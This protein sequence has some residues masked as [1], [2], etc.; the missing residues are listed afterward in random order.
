[1][2][3][4]RYPTRMHEILTKPGEPPLKSGEMFALNTDPD[5][6]D[7]YLT[8]GGDMFLR[9]GTANKTVRMA[10]ADEVIDAIIH[11]IT[12]RPLQEEDDGKRGLYSKYKVT[13]ADGT[14][15]D[16]DCFVLRPDRDEAA[17]SA[18]EAYADATNNEN[19]AADIRE[20]LQTP[21]R[22]RLTE[23]QVAQLKALVTLGFKWLA[24][25]RKGYVMF[26]HKK[27]HKNAIWFSDTG[28]KQEDYGVVFPNDTH[29][30]S[31]V[32]WSDP[33]PL[34]IVQTLRDAGVEVEG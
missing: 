18:L 19:L 8:D 23:E 6:M 12:R 14:P 29:L 5:D 10:H 31:L 26:F 2:S 27:P 28:D 32:T 22:P 7:Y 3:D 4:K 16:G 24:K 15:L 34:D 30:S 33:A 25:D 17:I 9:Y 13:K 20:W 11:G 1:M 21:R